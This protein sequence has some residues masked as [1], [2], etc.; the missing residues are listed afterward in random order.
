M[1]KLNPIERSQYINKEYKEYLKSSFEFGK[2]DLQK[3]FVGQLEREKL[4]KGPYVDMSYPFERGK[5][6]DELIDEGVICKSFHKLKDINFTRPLYKHQEE[7]LRLIGSGRSAIVTTG[8]GSGKTECFLY[9]ILNKL[10]Q[11]LEAGNRDV[12]IRAIFLYPMNALVNDQIDRI[13]KILS[14]CPEITFGFFTGETPENAS[15][16][17]RKKLGE[18]NDV[19]ITDNELVSRSEIR[20]NPPHLLFTNYSMLEYLLIRPNDYSLFI[21]E[22]LNNW[23]YVVLDEAHSYSGSLGIELSLLLR[24]LTGLAIKKPQFILTSATL[25]V[26]GK[27]E[28]DIVRFAHNLTSVEYDVSD[29][30]FS[31]RIPLNNKPE[32]RVAGNDYSQIKAYT[33]NVDAVKEIAKKYYK[34]SSTDIKELLYE[35]LS[36]DE[37]V[38]DISRL[39]GKG[40]KSFDDL[41][42]ALS[43]NI[44]QDQLIAL[45]DLI[46]YAE[47][48][49]IGLFDLKYHSFVRPLSGAYITYGKNPKLSLTKTNEIDGMKAF[50]IGNCRYCNSPYIIGKIQRKEDDQLEYLLQNKEIDIYENYGNEEFVRIDYFLLQNAINEEEVESDQIEPYSVCAKCGEIHM[51]QNLNA[52]KCKCGEEYRFTVY[53]VLQG[54]ESGE[55]IIYNNISQCPCC[56]H[57]GKSGVVKALNIGKDEGTALIAQM[58]YEAIDEGESEKKTTKKLSLK[59]I[60]APLGSEEKK[61]KQYLEFSDSR[62]QASFAAVFFDSNHVRMLRKRLIWEVITKH[63]YAEL[64]VDELTAYLEDIISRGELF[65]NTLTSHKNA[66]AAVLVDLLRIDGAYDG[67]GLGLYY[68]DL[69]IKSMLD[70]LE[71]NDIAEAFDGCNMTKEKLYTFMQ[72]AFG[73]FKTTPAISYVKSTLTPEEKKDI[74]E[75]RRFSNYV[76]LSNPKKAK[77]GESEDQTFNGIRS[78]LP[79]SGE[80][81]MV[82]RYTMKAFGIDSE[83]AKNALELIFNLLIQTI[84]LAGS[85]KFV[86]KHEKKD[87]YQ[88]DA[89]HYIV[90]NYKT[91]KFYQCSKCGRLTPY[92]IN[93]KCVQDKCMGELKEVD[94]DEALATNYYRQ[95]YKNK[96]IEKIVIKE[97]TAQLE[98]KQAKQY[99]IDFK[100]KKINILSCSTTFEM[101]ID[102][103][104]LETVFMRNVPPTP[105]NYVQRAGRAG[106]RKDSSAYILTYCGTGSHDYTY[107]SEPEKM[108]SGIINP[109]YF[110][111]VNKKIIVRHLMA[112]SLGYFFRMYPEYFK[113]VDALV[114]SG[115]GIDK[116][117][118]YM[119]SRPKDLND[120]INK[121]ILPEPIYEEYRNFKW[122]DEMGGEDEKMTHFVETILEMLNEFEQ[123]KKEAIAKQAQGDA[124]ASRNVTYFMNQIKNLQQEDVIKCL[125]KYC[126]IP[127]YG[128]PVDVVD[129]Q[130]YD[131][132]TPVNK[133]DL[134]RDLKIAISEYAPDSEIIVDGNK[135]TSKYITLKKQSEFIKNWFVACPTCKRINVFLNKGDNT[136]CKYCGQ[137]ISTSIAE[138]YIEPTNGFKSGMTKESTR[139]KPKRSYAGEVSYVGNGKTDETRLILGNA[140]GVETSSE[141]ELLVLNK[142]GFYMCPDCGY[143]DLVKRGGNSP[144]RL[145]KHKNFKQYD[146]PNDELGYLR[147][148]HKFQT[149]V[150]RFTIPILDTRDKIGYPQALS[151]LYA[152]LEGVSLALGIE[153]NDIDGVL[154]L[155]REW[156]SYDIILY[157][158]VPGGAGHVKRLLNRDAVVN[159][160]KA[161]LDKVSKPCC[162]ENTSCYNCLRNYYN[163]SYHNK[164]QRKL[165]IDAIKRLLFEIGNSSETFQ[166]E[167]WHFNGKQAK[168][169]LMKVVLGSDGRNPGNETADEIWSDLLDDCFEQ[170]EIDL[171]E[172]LK[173]NSPEI[174]SRP[175]Y[176]KTVKIEE[177]DEELLVNLLW[178]EK[179]T[180][181]FLDDAYDDYLKAEKTGWNVFCTK[182]GFD[183]DELL[184]KVSL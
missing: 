176:N 123:A 83:K 108:I 61:I 84:E 44:T 37:N 138:Y 7:A 23:K 156:Q 64:N 43:K 163:Q 124:Q 100:N 113:T 27:S 122:L 149:D 129:L 125:S 135:Y 53:K 170:S 109:P 105:A 134:S 20:E 103:G 143:S 69:D 171:I 58:L 121:K 63:N 66:W 115:G 169:K 172:K 168:N 165:A 40:S 148:G 112:T 95:Q 45:I 80:T 71:D 8:T 81:N 180:M 55:D 73:V 126:V 56:G 33:A 174:I 162:D 76:T 142:S 99:Q 50:E 177:T 114:I 111:V 28:N 130:I 65:S 21:P 75:Y 74:L 93:N 140:L 26:Q 29:I 2:N 60:S 128:F 155:N 158:N 89:S 59:P 22:R 54:K 86:I 181:L 96:K 117:K 15:A 97:H 78:F 25:G 132:G 102:I 118:D 13:R 116:F 184:G 42:D 32:Y 49:G 144:T 6:I 179:K 151:F 98:R 173:N 35:L 110:N 24:R 166:K 72:V 167:Q 88:L 52:K 34:G 9:P 41:H 159:S 136:E 11:D 82:V 119:K 147:L 19:F 183:T 141:D 104:G 36:S 157:D 85:D 62:Q 154:D 137:S 153:R 152:F 3:L 31:S 79:V 107:F 106:R 91:S 164:L 150:A 30:I 18:E 12:G 146:C 10:L 133:Y 182:D 68:F 4:F 127:K 120:Y 178:E 90:R 77:K 145:K 51:A 47:K 67:E 92:N 39:L 160:L 175:Y 139:I 46:N 5:N 1:K 48:N 70:E 94:P 38:H 16:N 87:A 14:D 131:N 17:Y 101:G 161:G 57:K